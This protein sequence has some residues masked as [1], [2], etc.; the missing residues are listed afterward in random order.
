MIC[1]LKCL[2]RVN[3]RNLT[4]TSTNPD[5]ETLGSVTKC[6]SSTLHFLKAFFSIMVSEESSSASNMGDH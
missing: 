2:N 1:G 3:Y 4:S 5:V 6:A